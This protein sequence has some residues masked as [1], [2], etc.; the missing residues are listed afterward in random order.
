VNPTAGGCYTGG[1]DAHQARGWRIHDNLIE[2]FWC[3]EGLSE[4]GIHLWRGC[5][6]GVVAR[7]V[8]RSNARGIGFG[9]A[10]GG[11]GRAYFDDPCPQASGC[12]GHHGG[13]IRNNVVYSGD[14][15]LF[16]SDGGFDCGICLWNAWGARVLHNA[17]ASMRAPFPSIE[18]RFP[19]GDG[20]V[21]VD[22]C[23]F[24]VSLARVVDVHVTAHDQPHSAA[25]QGPVHGLEGWRGPTG[26]VRHP[27]G[28]RGADETVPEFQCA[29]TSRVEEHSHHY[30]W[31]RHRRSRVGI[32]HERIVVEPMLVGGGER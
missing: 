20:M 24:L 3:P 17:V 4:H 8:L 25:G 32:V 10:T 29:H 7:N 9:I 22:A 30:D 5:R 31:L 1:I 23:H 28:S 11:G 26:P 18:Y 6:D 21:S 19:I 16:E 27:L 2:G 12:V 14:A 13:I 15:D